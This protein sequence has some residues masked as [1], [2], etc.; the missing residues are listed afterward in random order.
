MGCA[1]S[2]E[3]VRGVWMLQEVVLILILI[4]S[5]TMIVVVVGWLVGFSVGLE[6]YMG[7]IFWGS[8]DFGYP[9]LYTLYPFR[10]AVNTL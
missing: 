8:W 5:C 6:E 3:E 7:W 1:E 2:A 4:L 9:H 10:I